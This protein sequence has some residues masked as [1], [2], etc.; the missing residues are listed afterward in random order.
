MRAK[1]FNAVPKYVVSRTL[2]EAAW[3]NTTIVQ[4]DVDA[5]LRAL[6]ERPGKDIG[7]FGSAR[8]TAYLIGHGL[9]DELRVM[10]NAVLLGRGV[11]AFP[12]TG[13]TAMELLR[14]RPLGNGNILLTYR[15]R[16]S[17]S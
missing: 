12:V 16:P 14:S 11:P 10:L 4:G 15:P 13:L 3:V 8:L 5:T 6:K 7:I 1:L 2:R 17:Q 9:L